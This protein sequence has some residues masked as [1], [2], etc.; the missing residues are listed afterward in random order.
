VPVRAIYTGCVINRIDLRGMDLRA[1][2]V[3]VRHLVPRAEF[4][5]ETALEAV[6]PICEDVRHRGETALIEYGE[7]FDGVRLRS[8]RVSADAIAQA[9][10]AL[11]PQVRAALEES[12]RRVRKV[13]NDQ[14]RRDVQ[15]VVVP[16]GMVT[17]RWVPVRR[18]GLYV[19]GG[20]AVLPSSVVM[21][22]VP[23]QVAGVEQ[24]AVGRRLARQ[25]IECDLLPR[26]VGDLT[27]NGV[28]VRLQRGDQRRR[29]PSSSRL[30]HALLPARG[31]AQGRAGVL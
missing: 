10:A 27:L 23:A 20:L 26:R 24:I 6:R 17:E 30:R 18:A 12:I 31:G 28:E 7:R 8:L 2:G 16:G 25:S 15:T 1:A 19:P 29:Q 21:N 14:K 13:H 11:D 22:V 5:V 3:D 9:Q 4:D